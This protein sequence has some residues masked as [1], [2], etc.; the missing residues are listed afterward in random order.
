[1]LVPGDGHFQ[2]PML[3]SKYI[4]QIKNTE[5]ISS[6]SIR[7]LLWFEI[8]KMMI[9]VLKN[10]FTVLFIIIFGTLSFSITRQL[11]AGQFSSVRPL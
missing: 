5:A 9:V 6:S 3:K 11:G 2:I 4:F 10:K 1:V 8:T 7:K